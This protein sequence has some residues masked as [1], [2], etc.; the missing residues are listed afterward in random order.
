M[1]VEWWAGGAGGRGPSVTVSLIKSY[2]MSQLTFNCLYT[3]HQMGNFLSIYT[4][5]DIGDKF[6]CDLMLVS[7]TCFILIVW[8]VMMYLH[9]S[10]DIWWGKRIVRQGIFLSHTKYYWPEQSILLGSLELPIS[11]TIK[12]FVLQNCPAQ[13][14]IYMHL[15]GGI[16]ATLPHIR[17]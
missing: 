12:I 16:L 15:Y 13:L 10:L 7:L 17:T 2:T 11:K 9:Y 6:S 4:F 1:A 8:N 5:T 3:R 14:T